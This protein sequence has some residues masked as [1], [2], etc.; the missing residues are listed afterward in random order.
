[1]DFFY[2]ILLGIIEGLTEFLPVSST[3]HLIVGSALFNFPPATDKPFRDTFDIFIQLGAIL[4]LIIYYRGELLTHARQLPTSTIARSFWLKI[5]FAFLPAAVIGFLLHDWITDNLF[6]PTVVGVM[7]IVG[8]VIFLVVESRPLR[9]RITG[10]DTMTPLHA[11]LIGI[12]QLTALIPG[13]SRSGASIIGGLLV[14]LDRQTAT[15]FSF[16]LAIPTLSVATIYSFFSAIRAGEI[17]LG[18][19]PIMMVGAAAAFVTA[20]FAIGWFLR[21][22]SSNN[23]RIFGFYRIAAGIII[24][25]LVATNILR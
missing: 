2:A 25:I 11:L 16:F 8:G 18:Q 20:W 1:M 5:F 12:A 10:M 3:G 9:P 22:I 19:M 13:V 6:N 14:G 23:F 17:S 4:A 7:L 15:R 24:L 21:Y